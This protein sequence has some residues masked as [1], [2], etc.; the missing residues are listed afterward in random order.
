MDQMRPI[1]TRRQSKLGTELT[2]F[3]KDPFLINDA[4]PHIAS[5]RIEHDSGFESWIEPLKSKVK[6]IADGENA[7]SRLWIVTNST[8]SGILGFAN[9][10]R[11]ESPYGNKVRFLYI[12]NSDSNNNKTDS[13]DPLSMLLN[14]DLSSSLVR[15]IVAKDLAVNVLSLKGQWGS[16]RFVRLSEDQQMVHTRH[17][18]LSQV[19]RG[20]LSSLQWFESEHKCFENDLAPKFQD[21]KQLICD[22][23]YSALNFKVIDL[24][25]VR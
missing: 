10:L 20:D 9:C 25:S 18:Y 7:H 15:E 6:L 14:F 11:L 5:V 3:R 24:A 17:A 21:S 13:E 22:V 8:T 1:S 4:A 12:Q 19:Q 2:L 23:F 16:Y